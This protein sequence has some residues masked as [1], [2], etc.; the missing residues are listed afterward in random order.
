MAILKDSGDASKGDQRGRKG[1]FKGM[2]QLF[3]FVD[4]FATLLPNTFSS[5][6]FA[7]ALRFSCLFMIA[8]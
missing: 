5:S 8:S 4:D 3:V 7:L 6:V 2:D 1:G